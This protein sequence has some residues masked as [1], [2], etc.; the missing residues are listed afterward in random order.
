MPINDP[1][2]LQQKAKLEVSDEKL[3]ESTLIVTSIKDLIKPLEYFNVSFTQIYIQ[4][5]NTN[6]IGFKI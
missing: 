5:T 2:T 3:K 6:E 1:R 4:S